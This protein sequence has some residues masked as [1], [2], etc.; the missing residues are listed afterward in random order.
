[1]E[2]RLLQEE[3]S[4]WR[5]LEERIESSQRSKLK[6][7]YILSLLR[8]YKKHCNGGAP[9]IFLEAEF[10]N[11]KLDSGRASPVM[12]DTLILG[13]RIAMQEYSNS[14]KGTVCY[15]KNEWMPSYT[16]I[17]NALIDFESRD[18]LSACIAIALY[19]EVSIKK[20]SMIRLKDYNREDSVYAGSTKIPYPFNEVVDR[21]YDHVTGCGGNEWSSFFDILGGSATS[22]GKPVHV[23]TIKSRIRKLSRKSGVDFMRILTA[24]V[25]SRAVPRDYVVVYRTYFEKIR[26]NRRAK[27]E[28]AS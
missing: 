25:S 3:W 22:M 17:Y 10:F 1:L 2:R 28:S 11:K 23:D 7:T 4:E 26:V 18:G 16:D 27:K 5:V 19:A 14:Y 13:F 24:P 21:Q 8:A 12:Y 9:N 20:I 15:V 6:Q